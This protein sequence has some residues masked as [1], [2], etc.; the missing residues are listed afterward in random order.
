MTNDL[1]NQ[2]TIEVWRLKGEEWVDLNAAASLLDD[3]KSVVLSQMIIA[4]VEDGMAVGKAERA[5][6]ASPQYRD[7]LKKKNAA[8]KR[9]DHAKVALDY[10]KEIHWE[11]KMANANARDERK[12]G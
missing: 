10:A 6:R 11:Q 4:L 12:M 1:T 2:P 5:A 3:G 8:R 7:Y 9:A